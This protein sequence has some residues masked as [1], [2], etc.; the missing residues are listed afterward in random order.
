MTLGGVLSD[1]IG[2]LKRNAVHSL[3]KR[4]PRAGFEQGGVSKARILSKLDSRFAFLSLLGA[5]SLLA[6]LPLSSAPALLL[7][8]VFFCPLP[9]RHSHP[10]FNSS[11]CSQLPRGGRPTELDAARFDVQKPTVD[12]QNFSATRHDPHNLLLAVFSKGYYKELWHRKTQGQK[13]SSSVALG[14]LAA[15]IFSPPQVF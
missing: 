14:A 6:S 7:Y 10:A 11:A 12:P 2:V 1:V 8:R 13:V 5:A 15:A 4:P 3:N 9:Y